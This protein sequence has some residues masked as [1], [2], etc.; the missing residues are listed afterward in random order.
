MK[1]FRRVTAI[2]QGG[3]WSYLFEGGV[4]TLNFGENMPT[5][6]VFVDG[7][8]F[9]F[10]NI[11]RQSMTL[12]DEARMKAVVYAERVAAMGMTNLKVKP[13]MEFVTQKNIQRVIVPN[14]VVLSCV[15]NQKSRKLMAEY[16]RE[17]A[18][19]LNNFALISAA[20]DETKCNAHAHLVF[21]GK[22]VT[23]GMDECHPEIKN[24][25]D[26]NPGELSCE[27]RARLPGGGQTIAAN[28]KA[29]GFALEYLG[30]L[31]SGGNRTLA[32]VNMD[33]VTKSEVFYDF[34]HMMADTSSR[35]V[36]GSLDYIGRTIAAIRAD[37][38]KPD[39]VRNPVSKPIS[40]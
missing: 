23:L 11:Q 38:K 3:I 5:E 20:N 17:N 32:D 18:K 25:T 13:I 8:Q 7:D 31:L 16:V 40:L 33:I 2:G 39:P 21:G 34:R 19:K 30:M 27:E 14:S 36:P 9:S 26:K 35:A 1:L 22:E 28:H 24:P 29:A 37:L 6:V 15:D 12:D 10:T 4:R